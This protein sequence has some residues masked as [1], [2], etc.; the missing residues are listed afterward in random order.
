MK[1]DICQKEG[2]GLAPQ[3]PELFI[4]DGVLTS[5]EAGKL[6]AAAEAF[7]FQAQGSRG[8]SHGEVSKVP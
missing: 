7:G 4:V 1:L 5:A 3:G 2:L 8:A 6:A